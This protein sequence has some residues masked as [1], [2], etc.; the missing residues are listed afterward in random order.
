MFTEPRTARESADSLQAL[1]AD[2]LA[3]AVAEGRRF[4]WNA[5]QKSVADAAGEVAYVYELN[6]TVEQRPGGPPED[7][8]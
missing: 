4:A 6:L 3:H 5:R 8:D 7:D 2:L 1:V